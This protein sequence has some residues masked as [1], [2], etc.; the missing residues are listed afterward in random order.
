MPL[1]LGMRGKHGIKPTLRR[2]EG[3]EGMKALYA[4]TLTSSEPIY[5]WVGNHVADPLLM[6]HFRQEY[7][8]E[9][10][11]RKIMAYV[12]LSESPENTTYHKQDKKNYRESRFLPTGL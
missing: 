11:K 4:D 8:P 2:F 12:L 10:V 9:R 5:A 1:L 3:L 6:E 7:V